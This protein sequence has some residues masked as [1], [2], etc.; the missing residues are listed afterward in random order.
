V[1]RTKEGDTYNLESLV[2]FGVFPEDLGPCLREFRMVLVRID[3]EN[4]GEH[5]YSSS[6]AEAIKRTSWW[7]IIIIL[8]K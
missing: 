8:V 7:I 4:L 6:V 1:E 3:L 2:Q 5:M